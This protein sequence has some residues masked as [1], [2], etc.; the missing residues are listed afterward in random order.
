MWECTVQEAKKKKQATEVYEPVEEQPGR[1]W[2]RN[3]DRLTSQ[4]FKSYF[5]SLDSNSYRELWT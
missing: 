5:R 1:Q 2:S 3:L 4:R